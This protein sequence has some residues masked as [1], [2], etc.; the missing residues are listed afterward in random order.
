MNLNSKLFFLSKTQIEQFCTILMI[1][2]LSPPVSFRRCPLL[3]QKIAATRWYRSMNIIAND[4]QTGPNYFR[5][6]LEVVLTSEI[7]KIPFLQNKEEQFL[8]NE[9][10]VYFLEED[11]FPQLYSKKY[12]IQI[13][14]S[15][16]VIVLKRMIIPLLIKDI[17]TY[18]DT[19]FS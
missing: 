4:F 5:K 11:T 15:I 10:I 6:T 13:I 14:S 1:I 3:P 19:I 9:L 8:L 17:V 18:L 7:C 12:Q 2:P 16:I